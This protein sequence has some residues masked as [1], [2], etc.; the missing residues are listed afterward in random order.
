M[1]TVGEFS[2]TTTADGNVS[3]SGPKT[4]MEERGYAKLDEIASGTCVV[5]N[6][7]LR[8]SPDMATAILVALQTDYAAYMGAKS[9]ACRVK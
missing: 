5:F 8:Y 2:L 1:K 9:F 6:A 7:G 3:V 4:Y